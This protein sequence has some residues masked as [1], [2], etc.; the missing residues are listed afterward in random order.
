MAER[1]FARVATKVR[2]SCSCL[3]PFKPLKIPSAI[4]PSGRTR[5]TSSPRPAGRD[6]LALLPTGE[7]SRFVSSFPPSCKADPRISPLIALMKDQVDGLQANG[8]EATFLN[9]RLNPRRA[10]RSVVCGGTSTGFYVAPERLLRRAF[11]SLTEWGVERVASTRPTA[12]ANGAT[13]SGRSIG[14]SLNCVNGFPIPFIGLTATATERVRK[15]IVAQPRLKNPFISIG[16]LI[17]RT[18]YRVIPSRPADQ[19]QPVA[20]RG[21]AGIVYAQC[22]RP[23]RSPRAFGTRTFPRGRT[24]PV[25]RTAT[26]RRT[27]TPSFATAFKSFAPLSLSA[28]VSTSPTSDS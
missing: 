19:V 7:G 15:D 11:A 16:S 22:G 8:V 9:C 17:A 20:H 4:P 18:L 25:S 3:S 10:R 5:K 6:V 23:S 26:G 13:T 2:C 1:M 28:W 12:S 14:V 27:R 24:T 21:G